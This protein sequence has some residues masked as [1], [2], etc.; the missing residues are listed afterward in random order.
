MG[1]A[2]VRRWTGSRFGGLPMPPPRT[3]PLPLFT[4]YVGRA[5]GAATALEAYDLDDDAEALVRARVV[6]GDHPSADEVAVWQ[7]ERQVGVIRLA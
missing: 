6:L 2:I 7:G 4:F 1:G 3:T 5:N